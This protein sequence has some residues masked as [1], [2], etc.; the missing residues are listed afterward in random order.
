MTDMQRTF[1]SI[2]QTADYLGVS[3]KSLMRWDKEGYFSSRETV[4]RARVYYIEDVKMAKKWLDLR[5]KHRKHLAKLPEIQK[6]LDKVL[7]A[8]PLIP[9]EPMKFW[10]L[11]EVKVPFEAME[12]WEEEEQEIMKKYSLF[13][14][15]KYGKIEREE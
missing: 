4:T 14:N 9:G 7:I 12:K 10:R 3:K 6:A 11:E 8:H 1:L 15:W 2:K 13:R 5:E